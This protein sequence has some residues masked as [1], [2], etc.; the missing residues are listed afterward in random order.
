MTDETPTDSAYSNALELPVG[1]GTF[2][3]AGNVPGRMLVA[4]SIDAFM[5]VSSIDLI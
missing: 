5:S 4:T 3:P 1:K 2:M